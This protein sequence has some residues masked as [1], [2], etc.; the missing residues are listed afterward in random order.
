M[1]RCRQ[2]STA[3]R[4]SGRLIFPIDPAAVTYS[5]RYSE[6]CDVRKAVQRVTA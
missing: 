1:V 3:R 6:F 4:E 5:A 2:I